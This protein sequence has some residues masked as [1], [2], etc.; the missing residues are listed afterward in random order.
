MKNIVVVNKINVCSLIVDN[1]FRIWKMLFIYYDKLSLIE[2]ILNESCL[3]LQF[4]KIYVVT[5]MPVALKLVLLVRQ[6]NK[7]GWQVKTGLGATDTCFR[8]CWLRVVV[9]N[10]W[11]VVVLIY[12]PSTRCRK[13][14][15]R[16]R[17]TLAYVQ[18]SHETRKLHR[19]GEVNAELHLHSWCLR[20]RRVV[21]NNKNKNNQTVE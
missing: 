2:L 13:D 10:S 3:W 11:R 14:P 19:K 8:V 1:S 16:R 21:A 4:K 12:R 7:L 6:N 5:I 18:L 9:N 17:D 20:E 15:R